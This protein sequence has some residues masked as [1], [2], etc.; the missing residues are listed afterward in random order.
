LYNTDLEAGGV[1]GMS[2]VSEFFVNIGYGA[3]KDR[4]DL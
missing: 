3:V 1:K 4:G 2:K